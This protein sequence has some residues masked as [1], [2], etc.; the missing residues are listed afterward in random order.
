MKKKNSHT[1]RLDKKN[2]QEQTDPNYTRL[3]PCLWV[4][5]GKGEREDGS[6][7][8]HTQ[9]TTWS[10]CGSQKHHRKRTKVCT[11]DWRGQ[12]SAQE[13]G[14]KLLFG[15]DVSRKIATSKTLPS[16]LITIRPRW[17]WPRP[18]NLRLSGPQ[19]FI[20]TPTRGNAQSP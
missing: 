4:G 20:G 7:L 15:N 5:E 12:K 10:S 16:S 3:H 2:P 19:Q 9:P 8:P 1:T 11:R 17:G 14:W 13:I 6:I 18:N